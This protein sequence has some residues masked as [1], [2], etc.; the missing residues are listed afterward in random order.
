MVYLEDNFKAQ[1]SMNKLLIRRKNILMVQIGVAVH[2][3]F[4]N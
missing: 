1:N 2:T 4:V 3:I